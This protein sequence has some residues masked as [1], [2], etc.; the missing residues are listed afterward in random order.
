MEHYNPVKERQWQQPSLLPAD[1]DI[2][3]KRADQW[4]RIVARAK[5]LFLYKNKQYQD[6]IS[7]NGV[8]GASVEIRGSAARL[9]AMVVRAFDH[10]RL[11]RH[12]L[13]SNIFPDII[14]YAIIALMMIED[15]NWE[16]RE[17]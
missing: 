5:N 7:A 8:L 2:Y 13:K 17:E 6:G 14:N 12:D 3:L 1:V 10:G 4:D 16:G 11:E 9:G 15:E